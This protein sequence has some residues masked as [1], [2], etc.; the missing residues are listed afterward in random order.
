VPVPPI[1]RAGYKRAVASARVH[2]GEQAFARAW[3]Q[4]RTSTPEEALALQGRE[5][6]A[7][8]IPL[9]IPPA[10]KT[11]NRSPAY[12]DGLTARETEVLQLLA[13]GLTD[14]QIA[15]KL[16][17]SSRTVHSHISSIYRKLAITSR[18][19]ATRYAIEHHI[20]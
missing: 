5:P 20:A 2:L 12:P 14:F 3:A 17:L 6:T 9:L 16:V 15:E 19:A 11:V 4:G 1:E 18:S 8:A 13:R 10:T 7:P